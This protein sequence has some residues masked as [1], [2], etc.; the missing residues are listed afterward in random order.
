MVSERL[1]LRTPG[2]VEIVFEA[3]EY[4]SP[5]KA[6]E[7]IGRYLEEYNHDQLRRGVG[8]RTPQE[9]IEFCSSN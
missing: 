5:S 1:S 9:A 2:N 3:P 6:R 4:R 8:Y 7:I